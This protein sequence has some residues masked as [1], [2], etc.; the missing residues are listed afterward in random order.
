MVPDPPKDKTRVWKCENRQLDPG[1][2]IMS[3][4]LE[5][6]A[7]KTGLEKEKYAPR[8]AQGRKK[9]LEVEK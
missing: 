3:T 1:M 6:Q 4:I 7:R 5:S 2:K 9:G 8:P